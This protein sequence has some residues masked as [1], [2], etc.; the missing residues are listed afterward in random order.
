VC[1]VGSL[2]DREVDVRIVCAT[3]T[4]LVEEVRSGRF[5]ED[6]YHRLNVIEIR[7]PPLRQRLL[8]IP[9]L[10]EHLLSKMREPRTLHVDALAVLRRYPWPGN[11]RQLDNVL[12]AAALL[13]NGPEI[14]PELLERLLAERSPGTLPESGTTPGPRA[15]GLLKGLRGQWRSAGDLAKELQVSQRTVNRELRRLCE[16]GVVEALGEARSR[17]YRLVCRDVSR[18]GI[19]NP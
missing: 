11:V 12:R 4:E 1:P 9:L 2:R 16:G 6:L 7:V 10:A 13:T 18:L 17:R 15:T 14:T 3:N 5:R 19:A 8:D